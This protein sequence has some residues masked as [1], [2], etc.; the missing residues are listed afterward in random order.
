MRNQILNFNFYI[1]KKL[2]IN[3][4][5]SFIISEL[6]IALV[7][8]ALGIAMG[9]YFVTRKLPFS[10]TTSNQQTHEKDNTK[11][12]N[13]SNSESESNSAIGVL[14]MR[15]IPSSSQ[16]VKSLIDQSK[17]RKRTPKP[18]DPSVRS[19][20]NNSIT[21]NQKVQ[22]LFY[23][24]DSLP[25]EGK[26]YCYATVAL[27]A[28]G[29]SYQQLVLP[30][31]WTAQTPPDLAYTL[32]S[33]LISQPDRV[34]LPAAIELLQHPNDDVANLAYSLL[35]AYFPNEPEENYPAAVEK[36]LSQTNR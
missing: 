3:N 17:K 1:R 26:H 30:K 33:G 32:T 35:W 22:S 11:S 4:Q 10:H 23:L 31:I 34:K 14:D 7:I 21:T 19:I 20:L 36:F 15:G 27:N 9:A 8:F 13:P 28:D 2:N 6:L 25:P 29:G 12:N 5:H 24:A 18:W 16:I